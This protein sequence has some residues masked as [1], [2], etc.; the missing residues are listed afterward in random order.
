MEWA[1][2]GFTPVRQHF[3]RAGVKGDAACADNEVMI[4]FLSLMGFLTLF[5]ALTL[6]Q[7]SRRARHGFEDEVGFH[8]CEEA[9]TFQE[10]TDRPVV[11]ASSLADEAAPR[12]AA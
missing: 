6:M 12:Q 9:L 3:E 2:R 4:L 10:T 8:Y 7:A 5:S 1:E 11:H